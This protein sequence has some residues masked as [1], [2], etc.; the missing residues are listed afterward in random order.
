MSDTA[1]R[2]PE[3][4]DRSQNPVE[5]PGANR[6]QHRR[7]QETKTLDFF[8]SGRILRR[9]RGK[10]GNGSGETLL[11]RGRWSGF[12]LLSHPLPR[13][14]EGMFG[15]APPQFWPHLYFN[16][17]CPLAALVCLCMC[18]CVR[19]RACMFGPARCARWVIVHMAT[20]HVGDIDTFEPRSGSS[21]TDTAAVPTP[22]RWF[23]FVWFTG[24][25]GAAGKTWLDAAPRCA[26]NVKA[27]LFP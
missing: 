12:L 13:D 11:C 6:P 15:P 14:T 9:G 19:A 5:L 1:Q 8:C 7:Q 21:D 26:L 18:V 17:V 27:R 22:R 25:I 3:P 10:A 24:M 23:A 20:R 2:Q 4:T 16:V